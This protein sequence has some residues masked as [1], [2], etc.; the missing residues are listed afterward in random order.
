MD[1][2]TVVSTA[3]RNFRH[4]IGVQPLRIGRSSGNDLS[5][6][7]LNVSRVHAEIVRR[8]EGYYVLDAGG[9]NGTFVNDQRISDAT[10]LR[11]G[12]RIRIGTTTL[13][14]NGTPQSPVEFS[15]R[16]L[17]GGPETT[18]LPA[19]DLRTPAIDGIP[20][21]AEG[22]L[23]PER[24]RKAVAAGGAAVATPAGEARGP[25]VSP[26]LSIIY[27]A[28]QELVFHRPL[29]EILETIM[30]LARRAVPFERGLLMLLEGNN[31]VPQVVR[32]PPDEAGRTISISRTITDRVVHNK[33]S[34]LT[35]DALLDKRFSLGQSVEAQ[36]IRSVMCVPLWNN[37]EVIG[38]IYV[39]SRHRAGLFNEDTLRV[40]THLANVAAVKIENARLFEQVVAKERMEQELERA[41]EIQ[42]HLLP[43]D[44]PPIQGYTL[45]GA[46][47][48]CRAVG[49]DYYDYVTLP[50]G[51]Y[52]IGLGDVAGKG[53]PAA[54]LM[55]GF[56]A[57]L[58]ALSELDLP[59]DETMVRLNRLLY[60]RIP[61]NRFITFFYGVLDPA[62]HSLTYVNAGQNPPLLLRSGGRVTRLIQTG[63]PLGLF[64]TAAYKVET[65]TVDP[66]ELLICYSD[67]VTEGLSPSEEEFGEERLAAIVAAGCGSP[68]SDL[69]RRITVEIDAHHAGSP[70]LDDITLV[71]LKRAE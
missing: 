37:R 10:L 23:P 52:G 8:P 14:F 61:S 58:R 33:E 25:A 66:G 59:P 6:E 46:S 5:L 11:P 68:A 62:R 2:L 30:D 43:A 42:N 54:L 20:R 29:G 57:S 22:T 70:R 48:P 60:S 64:E 69:V 35:S 31:L 13:I 16:P 15:D 34:V 17:L 67:G 49:G 41:A 65:V 7:D 32:V 39:D 47:I 26:A 56:Q 40:L 12:D 44:G 9:K 53:L 45:F 1:F 21:L 3:G 50:G 18:V 38:L 55:C 24:R 51:R 36:H 19:G 4:E 28:D 71:V 27:E 63:R